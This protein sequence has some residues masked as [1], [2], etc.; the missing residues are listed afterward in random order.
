[1]SATQLKNM[2]AHHHAL[3]DFII[4]NSHTRGWRAKACAQFGITPAYLSIIWHSDIFKEHFY[5]RLTQW[6]EG[7]TREIQAQQIALVKKAMDRLMTILDDDKT[8]DRLVLDVANAT[9]KNL[10]F[11]PSPGAAP[12]YSKETEVTRTQTRQLAPG[13]LEQ[14]RITYRK[15]TSSPDAF[16]SLG[17][18]EQ[19]PAAVSE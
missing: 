18:N 7:A 12:M 11:A 10:G 15:V 6:R 19:L 16:A 1:M 2:S 17:A 5:E 8:D 3:V 13:I 4:E 14:A 9:M